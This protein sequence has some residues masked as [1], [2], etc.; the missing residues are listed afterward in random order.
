MARSSSAE[1]LLL[2]F[3]TSRSSRKYLSISHGQVGPCIFCQSD[4]MTGECPPKECRACGRQ[5]P[6]YHEDDCPYMIKDAIL[7]YYDSRLMRAGHHYCPHS[8]TTAR[9][10]LASRPR[11]SRGTTQR[12]SAV[13]ALFEEMMPLPFM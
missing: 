10:M 6:F 3:R 1:S 5:Y 12:I 2:G 13:R 9:A 7:R 4:R 8:F 11:V